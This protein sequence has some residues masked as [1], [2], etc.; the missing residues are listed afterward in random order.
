MPVVLKEEAHCDYFDFLTPQGTNRY[1]QRVAVEVG[2]EVS[3]AD[4][5][6]PEK[7]KSALNTNT[8]VSQRMILSE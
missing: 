4:F 3:F 6:K 7:L 2:L 1:F 5:T 8:K